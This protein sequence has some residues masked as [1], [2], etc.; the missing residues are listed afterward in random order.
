MSL[1]LSESMSVDSGVDRI[2]DS[3]E[4]LNPS[5]FIWVS[6]TSVESVIVGGINTALV[7]VFSSSLQ[8][9]SDCELD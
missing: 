8:P 7:E 1:K 4:V 3:V 5:S 6:S 2:N 9:I